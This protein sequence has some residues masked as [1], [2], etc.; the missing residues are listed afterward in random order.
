M[1]NQAP[2]DG[3]V[4]DNYVGSYKNKV[5]N[6]QGDVKVDVKISNRDSLMA[7]YSQGETSDATPGTAIAITFPTTNDYPFKGVA[8]NGVHTF[9]S[10]IVNE[11][12]AGWSRV[13]WTQGVPVDPTG[14]FGTSGN[15]LVGINYA[16]PYAGFTLQDFG[17]TGGAPSGYSVANQTYLTAL[18]TFGGGSSLIDNTFTYGDNITFQFRAHTIRAGVDILRYQ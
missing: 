15:S 7:R 1:P 3:I 10:S 17:A 13:R 2:R 14:A 16:Q 9:S 18:G 5:R 8:F 4:Q 6:D 11:F 12:R